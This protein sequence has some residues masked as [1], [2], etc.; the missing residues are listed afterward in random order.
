MVD[1]TAGGIAPRPRFDWR[2]LQIRDVVTL[3]QR[4]ALAGH[5]LL[6]YGLATSLVRGYVKHKTTPILGQTAAGTRP[7]IS[8]IREVTPFRAHSRSYNSR[9]RG[10]SS[11]YSIWC[12]P[13]LTDLS[14]FS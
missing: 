5:P 4:H 12:P 8:R 2:G 10:S 7:T 9:M 1:E 14:M 13:S 3:N 6:V 11:A